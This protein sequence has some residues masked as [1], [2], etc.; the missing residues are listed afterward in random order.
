MSNQ[1]SFKYLDSK[2]YDKWDTYV[3]HHPEGTFF[4]LSGWRDVIAEVF[5]HRPH[6]LMAL[7]DGL[8]VGVL[9]L[10]EQRSVLFGHTLVSTPFCVYGGPIADDDECRIA[11][12][13]RALEIAQDINVDYVELRYRHPVAS[14]SPWV[15]HC[16]HASFHCPIGEGEDQILTSIKRKQ[17]AVIRHSLKNNLTHEVQTNPDECYDIYAESVRN[18]GTPVFSRSLFRT[19]QERFGNQCNALVVKDDNGT[20]VSAVLNFYYKN[21]VFPYY[22]G[23]REVARELKSNDY[24][25]Y[26]LMV[27]SGA[28]GYQAFDFGR[29]KIG[30]GAHAYKKHWGM[31][32]RTLNYKVALIKK[33]E[34]P[35]LSPN[36]PKYQLMIKLWRRFPLPISKTIGP[37]ISKFLG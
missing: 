2:D 33:K 10:F 6:Y 37:A 31:D 5:S 1:I 22:G 8:V 29:S 17:R 36:N 16:Q 32:E 19:L 24:M 20:P 23:G 12:E 3:D 4:H 9:P 26:Q 30:S 35:D 27:E 21:A 15:D 7:R 11:L 25:Y 18:L 28:A 34:L 13:T 14:S